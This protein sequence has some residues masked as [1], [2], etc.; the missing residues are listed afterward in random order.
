MANVVAASEQEKLVEKDGTPAATPAYWQNCCKVAVV[1]GVSVYAILFILGYFVLA[2]MLVGLNWPQISGDQS[3]CDPVVSPQAMGKAKN[4]TKQVWF[5]GCEPKAL[6]REMELLAAA[7]PGGKLVKFK[8]RKME[9]H[10]QVELSGWYLPAD[11]K[12]V[13]KGTLAPRVVV[14]HG[15][16]S[17]ANKYRQQ[18]TAYMLRSI[19]F[20]VLMPNLRDHCGSGNS[21][22]QKVGWG[23]DYPMDT[24]GSWDY[25]VA[26]PDGIMGGRAAPDKV[27]IWGCSMGAF[28]TAT[29][30]GLEPQIPG[31]FLDSFPM[32]PFNAAKW[33]LQNKA[34]AA[35]PF[36]AEVVLPNQMAPAWAATKVNAGVDLT[37]NSPM[38][39]LPNG[40]ERARKIAMS[41]N[42]LDSTTPFTDSMA[43]VEE[44][45]GPLSPQYD[46]FETFFFSKDCHGTNHV[47]G[48]VLFPNE[49]RE[50]LCYFFSAVFG[51]PLHQCGL[52]DLP[53]LEDDDPTT[54]ATT[55]TTTTGG[56]G[57]KSEADTTQDKKKITEEEKHNTE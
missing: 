43:L 11:P 24:L 27:G 38:K 10:E 44:V 14:Q 30:F 6:I 42:Q 4:L 33:S 50:K 57:R 22:Y 7:T 8:S 40:P 13:T 47:V 52:S 46:L 31:V 41:A 2:P 25:A 12:R 28:L 37:L 1:C 36:V 49:Y 20:D 26:D 29:A 55:T 34:G 51:R 54:T 9:G 5:P 53:S 15:T 45:S 17:N 18:V 35:G 16:T 3:S 32:E 56:K 39:A 23:F 48:H 19:G 21:S